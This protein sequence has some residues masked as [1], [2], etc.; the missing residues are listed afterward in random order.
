MK[1]KIEPNKIITFFV[2]IKGKKGISELRAVLNP[3]AEYC[4]MPRHEA[5]L[6]GYNIDF[7]EL[8]EPGEGRRAVTISGI[9]EG[10]EIE[11]EEVQVSDL[12]CK[13]VKTI[14]IDLPILGG[15]QFVVGTSF[16]SSFKTTID[17]SSG[18]LTID[19]L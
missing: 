10:G 8:T 5:I 9:I 1:L 12:I 18:Y 14:I 4:V 17:Y 19:P 11:L 7:D 6:L 15:L 16:L 3:G 13:N 2:K